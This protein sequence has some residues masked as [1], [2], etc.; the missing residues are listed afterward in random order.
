MTCVVASNGTRV[1]LEQ[2]GDICFFE[3]P[4]VR[5]KVFGKVKGEENEP[6]DPREK[7]RHI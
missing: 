5:H 2:A 7:C 1:G 6:D 3:S 4:E